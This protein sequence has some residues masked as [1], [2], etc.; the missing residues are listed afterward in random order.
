MGSKNK[1][2][3]DD[4]IENYNTLLR[5]S[6]NFFSESEVYFAKYKV[7]IL[8]R[9]S[10]HPVKRLL[11]YGCGIGRNIPFLRAAFPGAIISGSDISEASLEI[12]SKENPGVEFFKEGSKCDEDNLYEVIFVAG[13][14]HHIPLKERADVMKVLFGRLAPGGILMIFEHNP[15]NPITKKI[16]NNCP[17]DEDA[18]LLRPSELKDLLRGAGFYSFARSYCLFFPPSLSVLLSL[19]S[20]LGWLPLGGQYWIKATRS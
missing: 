20:K 13:V 5:E 4:Y 9:E 14:F 12:A 18:V 8:S 16:V 17:Y 11:E 1:V 7:D 15:F 19:E 10:P 3:F 6:T 2:N